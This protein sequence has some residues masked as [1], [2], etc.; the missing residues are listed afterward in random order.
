MSENGERLHLLSL[1]FRDREVLY[2]EDDILWVDACSCSVIFFVPAI[3]LQ[4]FSACTDGWK[5]R[6]R[7]TEE[8]CTDTRGV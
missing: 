5:E 3:L 1:T 8:K 2:I 4:R 6:G 7:E